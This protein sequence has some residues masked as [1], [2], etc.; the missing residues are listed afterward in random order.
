MPVDRVAVPDQAH[1]QF[2]FWSRAELMRVGLIA[3]VAAGPLLT[4]AVHTPAGPH[5]IAVV[6]GQEAPAAPQAGRLRAVKITDFNLGLVGLH[7]LGDVES[8]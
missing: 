7:A 5:N 4:S 1:K 3:T 2:S 6:T 8:E